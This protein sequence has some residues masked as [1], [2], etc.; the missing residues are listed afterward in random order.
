ME[1]DFFWSLTNAG[2]V[3]RWCCFEVEIPSVVC[4]VADIDFGAAVRVE[5]NVICV[6]G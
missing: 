3:G 4:V 1:T 6:L 2:R 5:L